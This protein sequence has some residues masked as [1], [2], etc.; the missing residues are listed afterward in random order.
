VGQDN[1][2]E[3]DEAEWKTG[4]A[5]RKQLAAS[6][7][8]VW[9][10]RELRE[11]VTSL[12]RSFGIAIFLDRRL[13]PSQG[14]TL[15]VRDQPL[16]K[17]LSEL[18]D[19][20]EA[21]PSVIGSVVFIGPPATASNVSTLATL[22]RE[23]AAKLPNEAK[24]R[25]LRSQAWQWPELAEP[26]QLLA[27]LARAGG[28]TIENPELVPHDLWPAVSLPSLPW[29]DRLSLLLAGFGLT[30]ELQNGGNTIRLAPLPEEARLTKTYTPRGTAGESA[31]EIR[32]IAPTAEVRVER[33]K[34]VIAASQDD[35]DKIDRLLRGQTV[36]TTTAGPP[37]KVYT[38]TVE[39]QPAGAVIRKVAEQLGKEFKYDAASLEKLKEN[40]SFSVKDAPLDELLGKVLKPLGLTYKLDDTSL[41]VGQASRLP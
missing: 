3:Q 39:N 7:S 23:Q 6:T 12:S 26:P 32:K 25:L 31:S 17:L 14:V 40:V 22:R 18:A 33:G 1:L 41:A 9:E 37:M 20:V 8:V 27:E 16:E 13:D 10:E 19:K 4:P 24:A 36:R 30:F 5:L 11:A 35:H 34:L 21:K 2:K 29:T 38:L 28:V 15:T